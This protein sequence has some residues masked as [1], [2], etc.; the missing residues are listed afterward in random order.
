MDVLYPIKFTPQAKYRI[1][2]GYSLK[3]IYGK[4]FDNKKIG[5]SWEISSL[6]NSISRV[7]NGFL[8]GK[9]LDELIK[10]YKSRLVGDFI[11]KKHNINFPILVKIIDANDDLSIQT[12]PNDKISN[13]RHSTTGKT[14]FWYIMDSKINSKIALGFK[15]GVTKEIYKNYLLNGK[16][17]EIINFKL[18][19][20]G[21]CYLIE[22]GQVHAIG[23]GIILAEIQQ[24]SDIT[25]RIFDYN[26]L[27][28]DG[29]KRELHTDL[30]EDA[31][32]FDNRDNF[33]LNNKKSKNL[34]NSKYFRTDILKINNELILDFNKI[35]SFSIFICIEGELKYNDGNNEGTLKMGSTILIPAEIKNI[36]LKGENVNLLHVYM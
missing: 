28:A 12:H 36:I 7:S 15:N 31:I 34:V 16:I 17:E 27:D 35:D 30:A 14:E 13:I 24:T 21:D 8:K 5:E 25:Y 2:G 11:Y 32:D 20:P 26:R 33:N 9:G 19:N 6:P 4:P 1:W 22:P 18:I 29:K 10:T 3:T 23:K